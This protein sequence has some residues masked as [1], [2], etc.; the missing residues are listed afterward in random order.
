MADNESRKSVTGVRSHGGAEN[1]PSSGRCLHSRPRLG[2]ARD[3]WA[4]V[5]KDM[6]REA[7]KTGLVILATL[8]MAV[9]NAITY[10]SLVLAGFSSA[11]PLGGLSIRWLLDAVLE[12][13]ST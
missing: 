6:L 13:L 5:F 1:V 7:P 2:D 8:V 11:P 10:L 9:I 3:S 12:L 4:T